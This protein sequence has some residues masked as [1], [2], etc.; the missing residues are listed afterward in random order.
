MNMMTNDKMKTYEIFT[1]DGSTK[2][3]A[4]TLVTAIIVHLKNGNNAEDV[5]HVIE[6]DSNTTLSPVS[7]MLKNTSRV[8][9][10]DAVRVMTMN[11]LNKNKY[12]A[13]TVS[14]IIDALIKVCQVVG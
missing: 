14:N 13:E 5:T 9:L 3:K 1:K 2:V 11:M 12:T 4:V 7:A 6:H 10:D 8:E